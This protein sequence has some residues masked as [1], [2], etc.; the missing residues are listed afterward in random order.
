MRTFQGFPGS[1]SGTKSVNVGWA[2][3][4]GHCASFK[5]DAPLSPAPESG[6]PVSAERPVDHGLNKKSRTY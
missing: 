3:G 4:A 6:H 1:N 2:G 5:S